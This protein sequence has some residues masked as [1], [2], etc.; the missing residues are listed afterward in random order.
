MI[1]LVA[2][3]SK[4]RVI[5]KDGK[6]PW[7]IEED[8]LRFYNLT[9]DKTII[10]GRKTF[11]SLGKPLKRRRNVVL[12]RK[13]FEAVGIE[14][15]PNLGSALESCDDA[16]IIGGE[17][18]YR[19]AMPLADRLELTIVDEDISGDRFFPELEGWKEIS[20]VDKGRF[21]FIALDR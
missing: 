1:T 10:M 7:S 2:I 21:A 6:I 9:K 14:V 16:V 13:G 12:S 8:K 3:M 19:Q 15:F 18:V 11:E 20:K 4:N 17:E 5:A